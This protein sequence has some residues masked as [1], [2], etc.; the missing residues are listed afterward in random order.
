MEATGCTED[1]AATALKQ[2]NGHAKTAITMLLANCDAAE[3]RRRLEA[4]HGHVTK[5][6][7]LA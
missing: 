3:A 2:A 7:T 4:A 5:A 6:I 1:E